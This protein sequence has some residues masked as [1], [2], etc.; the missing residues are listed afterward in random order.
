MAMNSAVVAAGNNAKASEYNNLRKDVNNAVKD[1]VTDTDGATVT[2][3]FTAGAIH[4]VTIAGNRTIAFSGALAGQSIVLIVKQDGTGSR[5]LTWPTIKWATATTPTLT[6][7]A[8]RT[9]IFVIFYDGTDYYGSIVG[10]NY[11]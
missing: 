3:D 4:K 1:P 7:T 10:L 2:L 9:D 11:G 6:T 5:L 8:G